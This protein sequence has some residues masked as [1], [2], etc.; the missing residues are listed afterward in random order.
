MQAVDK[1][2][3]DGYFGYA[4]GETV[5]EIA[6]DGGKDGKA[7]ILWIGWE[8][9]EKHMEFRQTEVFKENIRLLR[10]YNGGATVVSLLHRLY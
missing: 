4:F 5:E 8:S 3:P 7:V 10:E 2:R 9:K 1:K 6:K